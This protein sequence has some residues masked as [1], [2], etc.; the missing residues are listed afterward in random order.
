MQAA[1]TT[2][3]E[4]TV[5]EHF[6]A[7]RDEHHTLLPHSKVS[8]NHIS[9]RASLPPADSTKSISQVTRTRQA[10][11]VT[12]GSNLHMQAAATTRYEHTVQEHFY[13]CRDEHQDLL[14][15]S[16]VSLNHITHRASLPPADSTKSIS[17]NERTIYAMRFRQHSSLCSCQ[18]QGVSRLLASCY[19]AETPQ[20][21]FQATWEHA[22]AVN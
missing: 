6:Y 2:R 3:Y 16:K 18:A 22:A 21:H 4:H 15:H 19:L 5:Q 1:A 12:K 17:S 9:H 13:A 10:C 11:E 8:L 14:P 20:E 7:C